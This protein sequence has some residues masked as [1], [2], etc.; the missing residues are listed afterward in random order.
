M[1]HRTCSEEVLCRD[2]KGKQSTSKDNEEPSDLDHGLLDDH[3]ILA[4][5]LMDPKFKQLT[6][7]FQ[8]RGGEKQARFSFEE[9]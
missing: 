1:F 4:Y 9:V 3:H 6:E 5:L 7:R 8:K 2:P